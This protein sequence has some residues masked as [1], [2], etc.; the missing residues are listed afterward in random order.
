MYQVLF[1]EDDEDIRFL[2]SRYRLW[3]QGQFRIA[4]TAG[5][6]REALEKLAIF[7]YDLVITDIRMPV[8]DGLELCRHI[9]GQGYDAV[10]VLASTYS[11]FAYAKEGMRLGAVE[12]IEKPYSEEKLAEALKLAGQLLKGGDW[13]N[14]LFHDLMEG[15]ESGEYLA[16]K[17]LNGLESQYPSSPDRVREEIGSTLQGVFRRM[18]QEAP[19]L[20]ILERADIYIGENVV[21]DT[22]RVIQEFAYLIDRYRLRNPDVTVGK[23]V[24]IMEHNIARERIQDYL[25]EQLELSKDYMGKLFRSR[26][27]VTISD[28]CTR[29]RMEKAK[30]MLLGTNKKVYEISEELGYATVDYFTRLFKNY[31]GCTPANYKRSGK[32]QD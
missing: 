24:S 28:Y 15:E 14:K 19:W 18:A 1:V 25:A 12:Y 26:L 5:N 10:V 27:G 3:K 22:Q 11:D 30:S 20:E 4:G 2:V 32:K 21:T 23:M 13:E 8:M 29:M 31:T 17:L 7:R 6:G 16:E 9:R